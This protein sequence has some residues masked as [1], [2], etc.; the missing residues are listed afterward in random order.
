LAPR[1]KTAVT[2]RNGLP[3]SQRYVYRGAGVETKVPAEAGDWRC[4]ECGAVPAAALV[5]HVPHKPGCTVGIR[6]RRLRERAAGKK[7]SI[8][9]ESTP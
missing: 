8:P 9:A 4:P 1:M 5:V 7:G 3:E 6:A 2:R